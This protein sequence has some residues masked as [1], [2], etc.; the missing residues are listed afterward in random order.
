MRLNLSYHTLPH[1]FSQNTHD[2]TFVR[3]GKSHRIKDTG[4]FENAFSVRKGL[5]TVF[6]MIFT[7]SAGAYTTE[8]K[9]MGDDMHDRVVDSPPPKEIS[10]IIRFSTDSSS[11]NRYNDKGLGCSLILRMM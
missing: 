7:H 10:S 5:K 11:E 1:E 8:G 2:Q 9:K 4:A 6:A 3:L